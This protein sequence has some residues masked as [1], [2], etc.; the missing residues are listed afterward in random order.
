MS[1]PKLPNPKVLLAVAGLAM[2]LFS[3]IAIFL[4]AGYTPDMR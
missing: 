4:A 3:A 2:L 1:D